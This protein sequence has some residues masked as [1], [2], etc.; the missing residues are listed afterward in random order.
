LQKARVLEMARVEAAH[1][2]V[3]IVRSCLLTYGGCEDVV[4]APELA[5]KLRELAHELAVS[6]VEIGAERDERKSILAIGDMAEFSAPVSIDFDVGPG[7]PLRLYVGEIIAD[8]HSRWD[9]QS[10]LAAVQR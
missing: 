5:A 9:D 2:A 1:A 4:I 7:E 6:R 10:I 3:E 8:S